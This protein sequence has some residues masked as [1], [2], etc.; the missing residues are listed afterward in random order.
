M[1]RLREAATNAKMKKNLENTVLAII[2]F[3]NIGG[4]HQRG[5]F[6]RVN[7]KGPQEYGFR[8]NAKNYD[9]NRD[10]IKTD[11]QNMRAFATIFQYWQPDVFV[12]NH[13]TNG[14]DYQHVLTYLA[15]QPDK[16]GGSLGQ[17]LRQSMIPALEKALQAR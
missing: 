6:S 17:Y 15:T 5:A 14:A 2:P 4:V 10:F 12:D 13:V 1:L 7:Q 8:G 11:S 16:L 3:Y 9:L